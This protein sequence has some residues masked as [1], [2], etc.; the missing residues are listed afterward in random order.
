MT[1]YRAFSALARFRKHQELSNQP[2]AGLR[3]EAGEIMQLMFEARGIRGISDVLS[4]CVLLLAGAVTSFSQVPMATMAQP[5]P[6]NTGSQNRQ[7]TDQIAE[8]RHQVLRLQIA[9]EQSGNSN[10]PNAASGMPTGA[11]KSMGMMDEM[12]GM[13][14]GM[15]DNPDEMAGMVAGG[16]NNMVAPAKGMG[17]CC[18]GGMGASPSA[19]AGMSSAPS[20]PG[21]PGTSSPSSAMAGQAG[22]SH[23]LH[24]GSTGFFLNHPQHITLTADQKSGLNLLKEKARLDQAL[25]QRKIDRSEQELYNVTG[26]DQL[27]NSKI[28][29]KVGEIEKLRGEQRMSFIRAVG[30][31]SNL[32]THDQHQALLGILPAPQK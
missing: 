2:I 12:G 18:M 17:M 21:M 24:I 1:D 6:T 31:A 8:M 14:S 10:R 19:T 4:A 27:D 29:A 23:L 11:G 5:A 26:A 28:Q 3:N 22:V 32:L 20:P 15:K 25:E 9:L 13:K 7:L 16:G 30:E